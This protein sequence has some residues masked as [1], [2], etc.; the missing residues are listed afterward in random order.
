[1]Q[2]YNMRILDLTKKANKNLIASKTRTILTIFSILVGAFVIT[3]TMGLGNGANSF[4][5]KQFSSIKF[6]HS[7]IIRSGSSSSS[8]GITLAPQKYSSKQ[9]N[10][11]LGISFIN[12]RQINII[13]NTPGIK[14]VVPLYLPEVKYV[15]GKNN[16][17]YQFSVANYP[18]SFFSPSLT[19]GNLPS[20]NENNYIIIPSMY[21]KP[22]GFLSANN[23]IGKK[24]NITY[25]NLSGNTLTKSYTIKGVL[26]NS[27]LM[28]YGYIS[29]ENARSITSFEDKGTNLANSY[30]E[31][32]GVYKKGL[33]TN[34]IN[35]MKSYLSKNSM[36]AL[37]YKDEIQ[38][39]NYILLSIE[40][41]LTI[42]ALIALFVASVGIINTLFMS[43]YQRTREIGLMK[44]IGMSSFDIFKM[45]SIEAI[46]VGFWGGVIGSLL[47]LF[48]GNFI[49]K[50]LSNTILKSFHGYTLLIFSPI[51]IILIIIFL[52]IIG[53]IAGTIPAIKASRIDPID[54]LR[55]Q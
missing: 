53:F 14:K 54:A 29:T 41:I 45:F 3:L 1:M 47:A 36:S 31:V 9:S 40:A 6:A 20:P 30:I 25:K 24:I 4:I 5:Q 7:L 23:A 8:V 28:S 34:Q 27:V 12:E 2:K 38:S 42:F 11:T 52:M 51:Q 15:E 16:T 19:A 44:A 48:V 46:S 35:K 13:K 39:I 43:V 55:F 32:I 26:I 37:T 10:G 33:T 49:N 50:A 17:K 22:L 21:V 18:G